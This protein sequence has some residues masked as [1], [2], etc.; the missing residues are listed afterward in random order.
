MEESKFPEG[1]PRMMTHNNVTYVVGHSGMRP[2]PG[3]KPGSECGVM[4]YWEVAFKQHPDRFYICLC[5]LQRVDDPTQQF[6]VCAL[7]PDTERQQVLRRAVFSVRDITH[8]YKADVNL[9]GRSEFTD[10]SEKFFQEP[11]NADCTHARVFELVPSTT[12]TSSSSSALGNSSNSSGG[13]GGG[14][15][16]L[17]PAMA[18]T[19]LI[20][21]SSSTTTKRGCSSSSS[22]SS[23]G[24]ISAMPQPKFGGA[25][26]KL[27]LEALLKDMDPTLVSD[28]VAN[29]NDD[30]CEISV[31]TQYTVQFAGAIDSVGI[32]VAQTKN[33]TNDIIEYYTLFFPCDYSFYD[34]KE[35]ELKKQTVLQLPS[36]PRQSSKVNVEGDLYRER[37]RLVQLLYAGIW[38]EGPS[39]DKALKAL[40]INTLKGTKVYRDNVNWAFGSAKK[41]YR[42]ELKSGIWIGPWCF[43]ANGN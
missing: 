36:T 22:S 25:V 15:T 16:T 30:T 26:L 37:G 18:R 31:G 35:Y 9:L 41:D 28:L 42:S 10:H 32:V 4:M 3:G 39:Y 6:V 17:G 11:A 2:R 34:M 40:S 1:A 19:A 27:Q 24:R 12:T 14:A 21:A 33:D 38:A 8:T 7:P 23:S 43:D 29:L 5:L 13:S 20:A